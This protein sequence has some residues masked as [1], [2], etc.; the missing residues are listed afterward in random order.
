[1]KFLIWLWL[2][3]A[4]GLSALSFAGY[5]S[6]DLDAINHFRPF[7]FAAAALLALAAGFA[8]QRPIVLAAL[9]LAGVQAYYLVDEVSPIIA[10]PT[11][12]AQGPTLRMISFNMLDRRT[13]ADKLMRLVKRE[14]PDLLVLVEAWPNANRTIEEVQKLLPYRFDCFGKIGCDLAILSR[15]PLHDPVVWQAGP[16]D[17]EVMQWTSLAHTEVV[18]DGV[19]IDLWVTHLP[20]PFPAY[21]QELEFANLEKLLADAGPNTIL[22]GDFNSTPWSFAMRRF[23]ASVPLKRVTRALPTWPSEKATFRGHTTVPAFG[24]VMPVDHVFLGADLRAVDIRRGP[25]IGSDH[26]PV[27]SEIALPR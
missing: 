19:P 27:I 10:L 22:A 6:P 5:F 25:Y 1:M 20:W 24:P 12:S 18:K 26:Y 9:V 2:L 13:D 11:A 7:I 3:A 8:R 21:H 23:D 16:D 17:P 15:L 14:Q 4:A